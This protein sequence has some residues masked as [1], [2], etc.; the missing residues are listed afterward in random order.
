MSP[1]VFDMS[2]ETDSWQ[3]E[4]IFPKILNA[5]S[6]QTVFYS[7]E[8]VGIPKIDVINSHI[9]TKTVNR[10]ESAVNAMFCGHG[11]FHIDHRLISYEA[12]EI[13]IMASHSIVMSACKVRQCN[14]VPKF[15]P[16]FNK[17]NDDTGKI[18]RDNNIELVE[19]SEEKWK[20]LVYLNAPIDSSALDGFYFHTH[21]FSAKNQFIEKLNFIQP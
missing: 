4:R 12:Q 15:I 17:F 1:C 7:P 11:M 16:P 18:C 9:F 14:Y 3:R 20:H 6:D 2:A 8:R 21:D 19:W 10:F 13:N 5:H